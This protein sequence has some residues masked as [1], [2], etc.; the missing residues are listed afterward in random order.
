MHT[1][2][3]LRA[4]STIT[5]QQYYQ[6]VCILLYNILCIE[7][8]TYI[9]LQYAYYESMQIMHRLEQNYA[10]TRVCILRARTLVLEQ[11]CAYSNMT[12]VVG[13]LLA[14]SYQR[15]VVQLYAYTI[16][17]HNIIHTL[18]ATRACIVVHNTLVV[19]ILLLVASTQSSRRSSQTQSTTQDTTSVVCKL[20]VLLLQQYEYPIVQWKVLLAV[21][22]VQSRV[23]ERKAVVAQGC[24]FSIV[25]AW[26][27]CQAEIRTPTPTP[28]RLTCKRYSTQY[29]Y[30]Y[31]IKSVFV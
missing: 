14:S 25:E 29:A 24:P 31:I 5:R 20:H 18:L 19:W 30:Q 11:H 16:S 4:R 21:W 27:A 8:I 17:M 2:V 6:L 12:R 28:H 26:L 15:V 3:V 22:C 10:S 9:L 23:R 7:T 1:I 13:V